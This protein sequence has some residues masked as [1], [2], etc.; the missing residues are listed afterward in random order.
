MADLD[1]PQSSACDR[2]G[3]IN[4]KE[5]AVGTGQ[6]KGKLAFP[7]QFKLLIGWSVASLILFFGEVRAQNISKKEGFQSFL[8]QQ[9]LTS[10]RPDSVAG[11]G[12]VFVEM[13]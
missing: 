4:F 10:S 8:G 1:H 7:S 9:V 13:R 12:P 5:N 6:K 3:E 2:S 11:P